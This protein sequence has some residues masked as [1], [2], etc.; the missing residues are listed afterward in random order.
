[1]TACDDPVSDIVTTFITALQL[2][3][4]STSSCP[5]DGLT[6]TPPVKFFAGD[7]APL[8]SFDAHTADPGCDIPFIWVRVASRARSR[9]FPTPVTGPV[10]CDLPGVVGIEIGV[11]WC[12]VT[13]A[14]PTDDQYHTEAEV[15]LDHS[16]RLDNAVCAAKGLLRG[17]NRKVAVDTITPYGPEGGILAWLTTVYV[18][19]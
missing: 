6:A 5:P 7:G 12:A 19:F 8:A 16:W 2:A 13:D 4:S 9:D 15:G 10:D 3:Y 14:Q 11:A 17:G 1:M 18:S